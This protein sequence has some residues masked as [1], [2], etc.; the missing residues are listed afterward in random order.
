MVT[1]GLL[2][3]RQ[4]KGC[5][6]VNA[7]VEVAPHDKEVN[8]LV[9]RNDQQMEDIF[10][11]VI[12]QGKKTGEIKNPRDARTLAKFIF[13][14]VKGLQVTAKSAADKAIFNEIILLAVSILD[15]KT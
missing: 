9:C 11:Q 7:G 12:Q 14:T 8:N 1:E 15:Q 5:F 2:T 10:C 4:R 13:N 6:L 3:G